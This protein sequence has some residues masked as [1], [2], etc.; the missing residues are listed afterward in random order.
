MGRKLRLKGLLLKAQDEEAQNP[1]A[2]IDDLVSRLMGN[3]AEARFE[4][5][6]TH[7]KFVEDID[8]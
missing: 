7:A 1:L 6:Q 8:I 5:I 3:N 4:F 2:L